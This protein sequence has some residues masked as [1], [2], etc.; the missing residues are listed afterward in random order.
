MSRAFQFVVCLMSTLRPI[1]VDLAIMARQK[2]AR[3]AV[4]TGNPKILERNDMQLLC[5]H[6]AEC[7]NRMPGGFEISLQLNE[8]NLHAVFA[9][10]QLTFRKG[11]RKDTFKVAAEHLSILTL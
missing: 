3:L 11:R 7:T 8:N 4:F 9:S 10:T 2:N 5:N 6:L 1:G